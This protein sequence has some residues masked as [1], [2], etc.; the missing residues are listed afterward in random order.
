MEM[1]K[2]E[3]IPFLSYLFSFRYQ[4]L[5]SAA[6]AFEVE[7]VVVIDHERLYNDLKR[8]LPSFV[9]VSFSFFNRFISILP[10]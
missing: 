2:G 8:D 3:A 1:G 4:C 5:V 7:S 6:E 10:L 9:K